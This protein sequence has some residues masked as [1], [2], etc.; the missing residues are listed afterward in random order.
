MLHQVPSPNR[1]VGK[2]IYDQNLLYEKYRLEFMD[3]CED[4][5]NKKERE[6]LNTFFHRMNLI[7]NDEY[8]ERIFD[9]RQFLLVKKKVEESIYDKCYKPMFN[10][11][12]ATFSN[13][14]RFSSKYNPSKRENIFLTNFRAHC[15]FNPIPIHT[16]KGRFITANDPNNSSKPLYV[17]CTNCKMCYFESSILMFCINCKKQFYSS[18]ISQIDKQL[19]PA[20]WEKYHC[21]AMINEQMSCI[22]CGDKFWLKNNNLYCKKCRYIVAPL[23]IDWRCLICHREFKSNAK[24]YNPLEFKVIKLGLKNALLYK[25]VVKPKDPPCKCYSG[26][27]HTIENTVFY[28]K[29]GCKGILY[30][31]QV[32][33]KDVVVC[34]LC[35]VISTLN[36]FNWE[37][38]ICHINFITKNISK[39]D[40][41][42]DFDDGLSLNNSSSTDQAKSPLVNNTNKTL[43]SSMISQANE[44]NATSNFGKLVDVPDEVNKSS[45]KIKN[46]QNILDEPNENLNV[47]KRNFSI[48]ILNRQSSKQRKNQSING[49]YGDGDEEEMEVKNDPPS[50]AKL[51]IHVIKGTTKKKQTNLVNKNIERNQKHIVGIQ[52]QRCNTIEN[53]SKENNKYQPMGNNITNINIVPNNK[54]NYRNCPPFIQKGTINLSICKNGNQ[55]PLSLYESG[56]KEDF[57]GYQMVKNNKIKR[58]NYESPS[59]ERKNKQI[60][61]FNSGE[62]EQREKIREYNRM[63]GDTKLNEGPTNNNTEFVLNENNRYGQNFEESENKRYPL[64]NKKSIFNSNNEGFE[65]KH[66]NPKYD[67]SKK[68]QAG[69]SNGYHDRIMTSPG[70]C[71]DFNIEKVHIDNNAIIPNVQIKPKE[72]AKEIQSETPSHIIE[73]NN[74]KELQRFCIKDYT[75]ITILGQGTFGKV[76]LVEDKDK[77]L[78]SMKKIILNEELD[79]E[80]IIKEYQL[81]HR[82]QHNNIIKILGF[83]TAK[84]D[85][86]TYGIYILMEVSKTDWEKEIKS[87]TDKQLYYT[88]KELM[89]IL[90]QLTSALSFLQKENVSHRDIKPQNVLI[91]KNDVYKIADF[92]EAKEISKMSQGKQINTLRGTELYMSPLLFNG[93]KT[94]QLDI[95]HNLFKSD[96]YSLGLCLL[97][98]STLTTNSIYEIRK[99][100][101]MK[102]VRTFL[103]NILGQ[104]YSTEFVNLIGDMLEVNERNRPDFLELEKRFNS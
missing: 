78:F 39:Y 27:K 68:N 95:K 65:L 63:N 3:C 25:I 84:L 35:K 40:K 33:E 87:H 54:N 103:S 56:N 102:T 91:F 62:N 100:V 18:I 66:L 83:N 16:C 51:K 20:T 52:S 58:I 69:N 85:Q 101:D 2:P 5:L 6:F 14:V 37:C 75:V 49:D 29:T 97:F 90:Y 28:H 44:T 12:Q 48:N 71:I 32:N 64:N 26:G 53:S 80:G 23:E 89:N 93:L 10:T 70:K 13:Y 11:C 88:E 31:G 24:P 98:A 22:K 34:S 4:I 60:I 30:Y 92:G 9:D 81:A 46:F 17:I 79:L 104:K 99:M 41:E 42:N 19:P 55:Q 36:K 72:Q 76:Y 45:S 82:L 47:K 73:N 94:N 38:P 8:G 59:T 1:L 96:V 57:K 77:N 21:N 61:V 7:L 67:S 50:N 15:H 74:D 43:F 86:T